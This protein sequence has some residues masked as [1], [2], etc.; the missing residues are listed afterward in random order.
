M[1]ILHHLQ[2]IDVEHTIQVGVREGSYHVDGVLGPQ[3]EHCANDKY[4]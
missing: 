4:D 1:G 2:E 3:L